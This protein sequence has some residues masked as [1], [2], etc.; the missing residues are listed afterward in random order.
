[1]DTEVE[2]ALGVLTKA[3]KMLSRSGKGTQGLEGAYAF[4]YQHLVKLGHYPQLRGKYKP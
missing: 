4:A 3:A 1:M 2:K